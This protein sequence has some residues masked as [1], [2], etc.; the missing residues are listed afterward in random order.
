MSI[1]L[2]TLWKS[3]KKLLRSSKLLSVQSIN[4]NK[5]RWYAASFEELPH[6]DIFQ[7]FYDQ[8]VETCLLNIG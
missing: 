6:E 3:Q 1:M 2:E 5:W 8:G 4:K 7:F